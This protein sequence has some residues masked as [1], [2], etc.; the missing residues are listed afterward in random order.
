LHSLA[1]KPIDQP[2]I[3]DGFDSEPPIILNASFVCICPL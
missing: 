2:G 1:G 3:F